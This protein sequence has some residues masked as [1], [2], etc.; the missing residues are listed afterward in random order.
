[1]ARHRWIKLWTQELLYGTTSR[2]LDPAGRWVWVGL[3]AMAGD[4]PV[5]GIVCVAPGVGYVESQL[6][7]ILAV[8]S[9]V[10]Q[11]AID[12]MLDAGKI[13]MEDGGCIRIVKW[14][15]YQADYERMRLARARE[16]TV[17]NVTPLPVVTNGVTN[18]TVATEGKEK[19]GEGDQTLTPPPITPSHTLPLVGDP[20]TE[21]TEAPEWLIELRA[22]PQWP[23]DQ[24][25]EA[26]LLDWVNR[27]SVN[28]RVCMSV[29]TALVSKW[30]GNK[31]RPYKDPVATFKNW[32][33]R[34]K[35]RGGSVAGLAQD[36][37]NVQKYI[38]EHARQG[39]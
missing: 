28:G 22:I 18:V 38:D 25:G 16:S 23:T 29:A 5:P 17:T 4:S 30:P 13:V 21:G 20:S 3:L 14:T 24:P 34:D 6:A 35:E 10:L 2:E 31:A 12:K 19:G 27:Q 9:G 26:R 33:L 1:M 32:I 11:T 36:I 8:P 37:G 15:H 7:H 39:R